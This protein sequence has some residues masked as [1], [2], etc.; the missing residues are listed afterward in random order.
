MC[1]IPQ[2]LAVKMHADVGRIHWR[3]NVHGGKNSLDI[4]CIMLDAPYMSS[5]SALTLEI[6]DCACCGYLSDC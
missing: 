3:C 1:C 2:Y 5:A 4:T 6:L